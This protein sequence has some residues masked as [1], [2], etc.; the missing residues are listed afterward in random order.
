MSLRLHITTTKLKRA[1]IG[2]ASALLASFLLILPTNF[3]ANAVSVSDDTSSVVVSL[4]FPSPES[5]GENSQSI[6]LYNSAK[7]RYTY[8]VLTYDISPVANSCSVDFNVTLNCGN[9]DNNATFNYVSFLVRPVVPYASTNSSSTDIINVAKC[10]LYQFNWVVGTTNYSV[11]ERDLVGDRAPYIAYKRSLSP[12]PPFFN[13]T[14][15]YGSNSLAYEWSTKYTQ[16][17]NGT[18]VNVRVPSNI[19]Y[20]FSSSDSGAILSC[21]NN[22]NGTVRFYLGEILSKLTS[23][24]GYTPEQTTINSDMSDYDNAEGALMDN[25][26]QALNDMALPD[27]DNFNSG[28]QGNAF[29]FISSNIEFFGGMNGSGSIAKVGTVLMLILALGLTSFVIGL[30][31]R[32][33][34][35]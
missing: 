16:T 3:T 14:Y 2:L 30:S 35:G 21:L 32:K 13:L 17:F 4:P 15:T 34:G 31:N 11:S 28:K 18:N 7:Q 20:S 19:S 25:N 5:F 9:N 6:V 23:D 29:Q 24:D 12:A 1:A 27:I 10:R 8:F 33:K 26:I 22:L